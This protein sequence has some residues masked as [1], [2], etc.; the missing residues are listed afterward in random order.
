MNRPITIGYAILPT[1]NT[2]IG[3]VYNVPA[4]S[5]QNWALGTA[6]SQ[7][8]LCSYSLP[9]T[10]PKGTW[11]TALTAGVRTNATSGTIT[12]CFIAIV[13]TVATNVPARQTNIMS[14]SPPINSTTNYMNCSGIIDSTGTGA[15]VFDHSL[16]YSGVNASFSTIPT[17]L[18]SWK[19]IRVG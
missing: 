17:S 6:V 16:T 19:F 7:T 11:M 15:T 14:Y 18:W 12:E 13:Y 5:V 8:A 2:Q 9:I 1:S 10:L 3:F 4:P